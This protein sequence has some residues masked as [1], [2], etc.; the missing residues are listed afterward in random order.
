MKLAEQRL[1]LSKVAGV[2]TFGE[3][4]VDRGEEVSCRLP[5]SLIAQE[6]RQAHGRAQ[7]PRLCLLGARNG[8]GMLEIRLRFR[9][10]PLRRSERDFTGNAMRLSLAPSLLRGVHC[11]HCVV[12]AAPGIIEL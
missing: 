10:V 11:R 9:D 12:D 1:G 4:I 6:P 7:F 5:L 8:Q 3:P 2:K